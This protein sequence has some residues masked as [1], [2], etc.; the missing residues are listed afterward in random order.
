VPTDPT[1][2][3]VFWDIDDTMFSTTAFVKLARERAM[4]AMVDRG[5][6]LPLDRVLQE[7][8]AVVDEF[9]S[10]DDRHYD[11]LLKRLPKK[12]T[13]EV[14]PDLLI[15]AGVIAYHETKWEEVKLRSSSKQLLR[16]MAEAGL[17]LGVITA[18]LAR[19]QM[20][21]ILRLGLDR[22]IDPNL[23]FITDQV[24]IAKSNPKL[25]RQAVRAAGV[26]PQHA[27]HVGDHPFS[28]IQSA[29]RAGMITVWHRGSGKYAALKPNR[30]P[31]HEISKVADLRKI[32]R[33]VYQ[34]F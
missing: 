17:K 22:Y 15:T 31:D 12:V 16:D 33:D 29:Q 24:G 27:M 13:R 3:A 21:K 6:D 9:G 23:I 11:R 2:Q 30:A 28:D 26:K 34:V 5:L 18:G 1:L 20:E 32:L 10:N 7:L 25:Y 8:Q 4:Q 19:K 14:N